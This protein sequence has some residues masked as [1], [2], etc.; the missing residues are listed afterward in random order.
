MN[1]LQRF[2]LS[3]VVL[4]SVAGLFTGYGHIIMLKTS[5][6]HF[7]L[8]KL[9]EPFQQL[10]SLFKNQHDASYLTDKDIEIPA[11]IAQY[12]LAQYSLAPT[13]LHL[14]QAQGP[15]VLI[16]ASSKESAQQ[17]LQKY[18][19]TPLKISPTGLVLAVQSDQLPK[20]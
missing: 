13:I 9:A 18:Q 10:A 2:Y 19:L 8:H 20:P 1:M 7:P 12:Q 14:N 4:F 6:T 15:L 3:V 17:F 11:V 5:T 16:D